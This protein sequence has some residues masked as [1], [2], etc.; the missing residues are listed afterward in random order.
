MSN[1]IGSSSLAAI[2][3][4]LPYEFQEWVKFTMSF[5]IKNDCSPTDNELQKLLPFIRAYQKIF[6]TNATELQEH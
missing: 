5:I 2:A 1:N 6:E 3:P 4:S